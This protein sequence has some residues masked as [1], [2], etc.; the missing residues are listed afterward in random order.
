MGMFLRRGAV[1]SGPK[2]GDTEIGTLVKLNENGSPVEFYVA[3]HDYE[4]GLNGSG[5]TLL[6]RKSMYQES[7]FD[8]VNRKNAYA[9]S[10]LDT[11]MTGTY[12][13]VLDAKVRT[14]IGTTKIYYTPGNGN[15]TVTTL[16]RSVFAL[17]L[18]ELGLAYSDANVEGSVL[19]IA[20]LLKIAY[21]DGYTTSSRPQLTRTPSNRSGNVYNV[22]IT[23]MGEATIGVVYNYPGGY[24]PAFTLPATTKIG[25]G[26]LITG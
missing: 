20:D 12:A 24:R 18:T 6:V 15:Y 8:S 7:Y 11:F 10:E 4:A 2:L 21:V 23:H 13:N 22:V 14:A 5:R 19:P 9:G 25:D 17:S 3:E 26:N 16:E 1:A